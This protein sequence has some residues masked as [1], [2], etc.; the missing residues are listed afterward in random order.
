[1]VGTPNH[2]QHERIYETEEEEVEVLCG[3]VEPLADG[4]DES[5]DG[6]DYGP[7]IPHFN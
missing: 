1:M 2:Y 6:S 3:A 4:G 7:G 5:L